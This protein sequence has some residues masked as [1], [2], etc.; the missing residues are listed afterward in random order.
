MTDIKDT[1]VGYTA[2]WSSGDPQAVASYYAENGQIS[3]NGGDALV[4][5]QAITDMAAGFYSEFPDLALTCDLVRGAGAHV[6]FMWTLEG[7]RQGGPIAGV[8]R[9]R[10]VPTPDRRGLIRP[11]P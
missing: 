5:R 3:I 2:A 10:G 6:A 9:C 1:A 7:H 11:E 8:V 4:G